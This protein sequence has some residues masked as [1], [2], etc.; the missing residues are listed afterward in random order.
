M[1]DN[2]DVLICPS[3]KWHDIKNKLWLLLIEL[4]LATYRQY[5][6]KSNFSG[7]YD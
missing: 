1:F 6:P 4:L 3:L 5:L 2:S 7:H